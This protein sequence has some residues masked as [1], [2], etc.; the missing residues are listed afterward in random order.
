[1]NKNLKVGFIGQG[2]IGKNLA[3]NF[4]RRGFKNV[5]RYSLE[6][7][8]IK[9]KN[10]IEDCDVVF[11]AVP[12]PTTADGFNCE[13]VSEALDL[14]GSGK[15]AVIKSTITPQTA[16]E[17]SDIYYDKYIL[18]SPEF[19]DE[20]TAD[21]DTDYPE[22]N[23]IGIPTINM[24]EYYDAARLVMDILPKA[25]HDLITRYNEASLIKYGGNCFFYMKNMFFNTL[26]DLCKFYKVD[27]DIVRDFITKD[28]RIHPVHTNIIH[29]GG[30]GAGG[31]CLIKD[32][33][34]F[35][36]MCA[37]LEDPTIDTMLQGA[38]AKNITLLINSKKDIDILEGVYGKF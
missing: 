33:A 10:K 13:I 5:V 8:Y 18:H 1:M 7:E 15:I 21:V 16:G 35:A 24:G 14:V 17:F 11:I 34:T 6:K 2:F 3:N 36:A 26:N 9:N 4:E 20:S 27:Y 32:F 19:L 23:V 31:D 30:R 38:Q 25:K 37:Q 28:P 29:K 22:R 12:T